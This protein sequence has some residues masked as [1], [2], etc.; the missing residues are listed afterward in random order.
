M[1][2]WPYRLL[3]PMVPVVII[4]TEPRWKQREIELLVELD[5]FSPT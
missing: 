2:N 3:Q 1:E 5:S 4:S